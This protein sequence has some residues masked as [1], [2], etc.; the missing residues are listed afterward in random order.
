MTHA[1][2][3]VS[4]A[5]LAAGLALIASTLTSAA[6]FSIALAAGAFSGNW[7]HM[8]VPFAV[9]RVLLAVAIVLTIHRERG[10]GR[11]LRTEPVHW[12]L[13]L[14]A[15]YAVVSGLW[16]GTLGDHETRFELLD[17][18]GLIPFLA[19]FF[20]ARAFRTASDRVVLLRVL[21]V[22]GIY[23]GLIAVLERTGPHAL[24][25]PSYI[26]D[27]TL[28][29]HF[30]RARGPFLEANANG[31]ILYACGVAAAIGLR[32][33]WRNKVWRRV[34]IA[35]IGLCGFG[36]VLTLTR[37]PWLAAIAATLIAM[38]CAPSTRRMIVPVVAGTTLLL[39]LAF[40][41]IPG[42]Q[43]D[44]SNRL[45]QQPPLWDRKNSNAAALRMIDAKPVF[46]FGLGEFPFQSPDYYRQ[47]ANY[48]LTGVRNVHDVYLAYAVELGLLGAALWIAALFTAVGSALRF[49]GPPDLE[50]WRIGLV[51]LTVAWL[52]T[53]ATNPQ[54][55][56]LPTLLLWS[57]AG[58]VYG[59][60][61]P[62]RAGDPVL[63][64]RSIATVSPRPLSV[65]G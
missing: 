28:G 15:L 39:V 8:G 1:F 51:A 60:S 31:F 42:L 23:L 55:F 25:V 44:A 34:A 49:R 41:A 18:F 46:G 33:W 26:N 62:R 2:D 38:L 10:A 45:N 59:G 48:P 16:A 21:T 4:A 53:G 6:V 17:R 12:L 3:L 27:P 54:A 47:A 13:G 7:V 22:L 50:A 40:A 20:A 63:A 35:S 65:P 57:W 43:A 11:H 14:A 19:F 5:I 9:D 32:L 56:L 36:I 64:G 61:R 52:V 29:I 58:I 30:D 24:V 37:G